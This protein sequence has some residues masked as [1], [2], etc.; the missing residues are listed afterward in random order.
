M[1]DQWYDVIQF[2]NIG[3][4]IKHYADHFEWFNLS[5]L[6]GLVSYDDPCIWRDEGL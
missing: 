2:F 6:F 1:V 3:E 4:G 5:A